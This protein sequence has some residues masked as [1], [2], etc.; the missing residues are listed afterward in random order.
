MFAAN[1]VLIL[2]HFI[3]NR[4]KKIQ[5]EKITQINISHIFCLE[6]IHLNEI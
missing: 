3:V 1:I 4:V 2:I 6:K 5:Y